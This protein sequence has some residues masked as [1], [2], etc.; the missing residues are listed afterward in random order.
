MLSI[1]HITSAVITTYFTSILHWANLPLVVSLFL[2]A[3]QR[4]KACLGNA[5]ENHIIFNQSLR[6]SRS[7]PITNCHHMQLTLYINQILRSCWSSNPSLNLSDTWYLFFNVAGSKE[8][9]KVPIFSDPPANICFLFVKFVHAIIINCLGRL[10][11]PIDF[12]FKVI[13]VSF[14]PHFCSPF[15]LISTSVLPFTLYFVR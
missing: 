3:S 15:F 10:F 13:L 8:S 4:T 6:A 7:A 9:L 2:I 12:H 14:H 11:L 1:F 5:N